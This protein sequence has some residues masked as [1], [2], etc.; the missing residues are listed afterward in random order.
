MSLRCRILRHERRDRSRWTLWSSLLLT[1]LAAWGCT[2]PPGEVRPIVVEALPRCPI[3]AVSTL[4][5]EALDDGPAR[6]TSFAEVT[7]SGAVE[8]PTL[9]LS[10]QIFVVRGRDRGG[11]RVALGVL[12]VVDG[13]A[14]GV[15]YGE[16]RSC[17]LRDRDGAEAVVPATRDPAIAS[18]ARA[19]VVAGGIGF[20]GAARSDLLVIDATTARVHRLGLRRRRARATVTVL[21]DRALVAGGEADAAIWEDAEIVTLGASPTVEPIAIALAE[22]RAEAGSVLLASGEALLVGGRGPRGALRTLEA[23]DVTARVARTL[24]LATLLLPRRNPKVV[25]LATGEIAVLGGEDD[26]GA[27]VPDVE[28]FDARAQRRLRTLPLA[29]RRWVEVV[30]LPSGSA[31]AVRGEPGAPVESTSIRADATEALPA[32]P[33]AA[34]PFRLLVATDGAPILAADGFFRFDPW[35]GRFLESG[36]PRPPTSALPF[37]LGIGVVATLELDGESF[38][39]RAVRYDVR[40]SWVV[41]PEPLGLGT[42]A[43]LVPDRLDARVGREG[44]VLGPGARVAVADATYRGVTI[45]IGAAARALPDLELR[46][47]DGELVVRVGEGGTCAWPAG[48]EDVGELVREPGGALVVRVGSVTRSCTALLSRE[49][50]T[51]TLVA[52]TREARVRG[53]TVTRRS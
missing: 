7:T 34:T 37:A 19:T 51:I 36:L 20:D 5:L 46:T 45:R 12:P 1:E 26:A 6:A 38:R 42:T 30:A 22:P 14:R 29:A 53:L 49:R 44:M 50:I 28:I 8:L 15:L 24:D 40:T 41:D 2:A 39:A 16:G 4:E 11:V 47:P 9:P 27:P 10:A 17:A 35:T 3:D 43:H 25:R 31:L 18:G 48:D 13:A 52:G 33:V 21:A 23:V 32:G